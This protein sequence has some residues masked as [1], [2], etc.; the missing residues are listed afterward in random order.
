MKK[1]L[2]VI[3][4]GLA[5]CAAGTL[6]AQ[7]ATKTI[8]EKELSLSI[9]Q[10]IDKYYR[11][12]NFW[13]GGAPGKEYLDAKNEE[14]LSLFLSEFPYNTPANAF[15]QTSVYSEPGA[16]W[17]NEE[18]MKWIDLARRN[19]QVVRC[20]GPVSPQCSVWAKGLDH[21]AEEL[22]PVMTRYMTELSKELEKNSDVVRWMDV[23]NETVATTDNNEYYKKGDWF[24]PMAKNVFWQNPWLVIG[25]DEKSGIPI[26]IIKA[27]EL[28]NQY[29]P[30]IKKVFNQN[31]GG[32]D[33][34][35]WEKIK[36]TILYLRLIG[37]RVDGLGWQAHVSLGWEKDPANKKGISDLI[38][39]CHANG[40]EFH[41]T[42]LDVI[43]PNQQTWENDRQAQAVTI[44]AVMDTALEKL[45]K[46]AVAV[47]F[48]DITSGSRNLSGKQM[49]YFGGVWPRKVD[50]DDPVYLSIKRSLLEHA[51]KVPPAACPSKKAAPKDAALKDA[52]GSKSAP[53]KA[54]KAPKAD[55]KSGR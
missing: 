8:N 25:L 53:T 55:K 30:S 31:G 40:L 24:G 33:G 26:Y 52:K 37:Q 51:P 43:C 21:T 32:K 15:K 20:H 7:E 48:W 35:A 44:K 2:T 36:N 22:L 49:K 13:V 27:F 11:E 41:V 9:R 38:D 23:V 19:R 4:L 39:W 29:A 3:T 10:I 54:A 17:R 45:G 47:N 42:E 34:V 12:A 28:A 14:K 6:R 50:M 18:Y 5:L 1:Y 46:G 16:P